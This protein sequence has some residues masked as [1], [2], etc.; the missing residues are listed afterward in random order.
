MRS[1]SCGR[2]GLNIK[3][4]IRPGHRMHVRIEL[5]YTFTLRIVHVVEPDLRPRLRGDRSIASS[6]TRDL[7]GQLRSTRPVRYG[8]GKAGSIY[9]IKRRAQQQYSAGLTEF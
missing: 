9:S 1:V 7:S 8:V 4:P 6:R 2:S 3:P 5:A